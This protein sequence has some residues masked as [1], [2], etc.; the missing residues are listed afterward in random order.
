MREYRQPVR[1]SLLQREMLGGIP[2]AGLLLLFIMGIIFIYGFRIYIMI[3]PIALGYF[4]MR[5]FTKRDQWS[6]DNFLDHIMQ[7][8]ILLP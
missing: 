4:V 2:Q 6:I 3:V 8:D 7:K 5:H 1:R